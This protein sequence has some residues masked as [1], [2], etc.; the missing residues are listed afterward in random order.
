[1]RNDKRLQ[2]AYQYILKTFFLDGDLQSEW[3][4]QEDIDLPAHGKC[5]RKTKTIRVRDVSN[6]D[7]DLHLLLIHEICH[8][9][10]VMHGKKWKDQ[11]SSKIETAI[12]M[13]RVCLADML[14]RE[15]DAYD[16]PNAPTISVDWIHGQIRDAVFKSPDAP[17]DDIVE[18]IANDWHMTTAA[19]KKRFPFCGDIYH[20]A[21]KE[22]GY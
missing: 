9:F 18:I 19:L 10:S 17:F 6:N 20:K 13:G 14:K 7:D 4:V 1:M 5:D 8:T 11:L 21:K 2:D 22:A 16:N 3:A 12:K 15:L